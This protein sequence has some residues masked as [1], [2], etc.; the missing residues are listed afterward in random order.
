V[1]AVANMSLGGGYSASLNAAV[2]RAVADGIVMAI[3]AGNENSDACGVSP[4]SEASALT[5]GATTSSDARASYSN[6]GSCVDL[7][8]PGSSIVSASNTGSNDSRSLSGTSMAAPHVA[9]AAALVLEA[10][11]LLTPA[12]VAATMLGVA[13]PNVVTDPVG[14]S[15]LFLFV[16]PTSA[17][18]PNDDEP[19]VDE[20]VV[21]EPAVPPVNTVPINTVPI[22]TVPINTV[23]INT[24]PINTVPTRTVPTRT[25]P[26]R[27]VATNNGLIGNGLI[28]KVPQVS[29]VRSSKNTVTLRIVANG[30]KFHIYRNGRYLITTTKKLLTVKVQG[31]TKSRFTVRASR[32]R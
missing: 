21:D 14:T 12:Q 13:T 4:A 18:A 7:F 17:T 1:P 29:V 31:L 20:P 30:K 25:V 27:S 16:G 9:G 11:P 24:V 8:A 3:A 19:V 10:S 22:N 6:F 5:V 23:P 32:A 28:G 2:A 15:N 26:T